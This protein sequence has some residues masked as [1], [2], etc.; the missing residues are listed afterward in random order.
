MSWMALLMA[1]MLVQGSDPETRVVEYLKANVAPGKRVVVS[2]L[3]NEVFTAPEERAVLD[4]LFNTFFKIPLYVAQYQQSAGRPPTLAELSE[5]FSFSVPGE[6]DVIL[7]IMQSDPR[8]PAFLERDPGTGEITRVNVEAILAH[9]R[10]GKLLERSLAGWLGRPAPSFSL[11]AV[12]G[13]RIDSESL[14]GKGYLLYFWFTGC[15]PCLKTTPLLVELYPEYAKRGFEI[16]AANAD[17]VLE[18]PYGDDQRAAYVEKTG[19]EFRVAHLTPEVQAAFGAVSI[20]PTLFFVDGNGTIVEHAVNFQE[21][22]VL[23]AAIQ[24]TLE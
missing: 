11:E 8:M 21:R 10:F 9:P 7:K 14:A 23:E 24:K 5:Q 18:L 17:R 1:A 15:P 16:V 4:R 13:S 12:D 22:E 20:F 6:T 2:Q 3:Y 19:I